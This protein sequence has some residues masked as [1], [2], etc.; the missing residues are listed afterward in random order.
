MK[1]AKRPQPVLPP[2]KDTNVVTIKKEDLPSRR[3]GPISYPKA[4]PHAEKPR[5]GGRGSKYK[6]NYM[7]RE[8]SLYEGIVKL[9]YARPEMRA[10]LLQILKEAKPDF[11]RYIKNKTFKNPETGNNV[12]FDSLPPETQKKIR[13]D[14]VEK[15]PRGSGGHQDPKESLEENSDD[16]FAQHMSTHFSRKNMATAVKDT[17]W[18]PVGQGI[19]NKKRKRLSV[20]FNHKTDRS[21][22]PITVTFGGTSAFEND[23]E[24]CAYFETSRQGTHEENYKLTGDPKQDAE[25]LMKG[26]KEGLEMYNAYHEHDKKQKK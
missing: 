14:Y 15:N 19:F 26:L 16:Y 22:S 18:E 21:R 24:G 23:G 8:A 10:P 20:Q 1:T 13:K 17:G 6:E 12:Q 2:K 4:G 3:T 25:G 9:A 11:D 5:D 7:N